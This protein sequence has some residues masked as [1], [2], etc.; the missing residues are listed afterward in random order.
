MA[1]TF[2][3]SPQHIFSQRVLACYESLIASAP[4]SP[5]PHLGGSLLYAGQLDDH[6]R[7]LVVASNI[8]GAASLSATDD[9]AAQKQSI[10]DGVIDFLV[11]SLDE[12]LRI[13]KNEIRK[14]EPVAVCVSVLPAILEME[15]EE[16]GVSPDIQRTAVAGSLAELNRESMATDSLALIA[17]TVSAAPA[18]WLPRLD[19]LALECLSP[20]DTGARR[21]LRQSPRYLGRQAQE[22]RLLHSN[23]AVAEQFIARAR[24]ANIA[25]PFTIQ[26]TSSVHSEEFHLGPKSLSP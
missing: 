18:R 25:V 20:Q 4:T 26:V 9:T 8:A 2:P 21:W 3:P 17:W 14:H 23:R 15:M 24:T 19:A 22:L 11:N 16:R 1:T 13:L 6:G 12:A 7:A 5:N 10:R